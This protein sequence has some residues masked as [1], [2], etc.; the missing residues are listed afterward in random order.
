M[1]G[2]DGPESLTC[3]KTTLI[4]SLSSLK[5]EW[6][7]SNDTIMHD[8]Q[9]CNLYVNLIKSVKFT[10]CFMYLLISCIRVSNCKLESPLF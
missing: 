4:S 1:L 8:T 3:G 7:V 6:D 9:E 5:A 2:C 10:F